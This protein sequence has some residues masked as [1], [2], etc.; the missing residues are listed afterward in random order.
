MRPGFS[1][2]SLASP[3]AP[4]DAGLLLTG[5]YA[6]GD[7]SRIT[8]SLSAEARVG[9][10]VVPVDVSLVASQDSGG[11]SFFTL[12]VP[13]EF[14]RQGYPPDMIA[15]AATG[16][17]CVDATITLVGDPAFKRTRVLGC[18]RRRGSLSA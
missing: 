12:R 11:S 16:R 17:V 14:P 13:S 8:S 4:L 1:G 18:S 15:T 3:H 2:I 10:R 7:V 9:D 5:A 6:G